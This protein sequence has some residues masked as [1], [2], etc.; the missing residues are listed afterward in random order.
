M[1]QLQIQTGNITTNQKVKV[2]FTLHAFS[3][4]KTMMWNCHMY[5]SA[6]MKYNIILGKDLLTSLGLNLK[7]SEHDIEAG[8]GGEIPFESFTEP[9]VNFGTYEFKF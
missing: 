8:D 4:T 6:K 5:D 2:N 7:L 1:I 3:A 9:M